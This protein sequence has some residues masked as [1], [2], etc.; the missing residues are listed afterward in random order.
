MIFGPDDI[1]PLDAMDYLRRN[2]HRFFRSGVYDPVELAGMIA[3]EALTSG[4][5]R[6]QILSDGEWLT[7]TADQDWL[8]NRVHEAFHAVTPFPQ[9]GVNGMLAEVLAVVFSA[10][11]CTGTRNGFELIKGRAA[12]PAHPAVEDAVRTVAFKRLRDTGALA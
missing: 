7:V 1:S 3:T 6:V 10:G 9:G 2:E 8:E 4:A 5:G 11:V 12:V